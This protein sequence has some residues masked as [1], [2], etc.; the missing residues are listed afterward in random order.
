[1][2]TEERPTDEETL[3]KEEGLEGEYSQSRKKLMQSRGHGVKK[4]PE[5]HWWAAY[6]AQCRGDG[7]SGEDRGRRAETKHT[8][9]SCLDITVLST[10][11]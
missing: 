5:G 1:M 11:T 10:T 3:L 6:E 8:A 9:G 2:T 7:G 4:R